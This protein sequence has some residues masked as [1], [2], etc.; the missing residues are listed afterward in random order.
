VVLRAKRKGV[1]ES[2]RPV[3]EHLRSVGLYASDSL[4]EQALAHLGE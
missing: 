3:I 1:I 4:V 2:A